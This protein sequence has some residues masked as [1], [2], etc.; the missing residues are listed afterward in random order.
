LDEIHHGEAQ[1][2]PLEVAK[3]HEGFYTH[4]PK[5]EEA[6]VEEVPVKRS[7]AGYPEPTY[8]EGQLESTS[9]H[10]DLDGHPLEH[11]VSVY[12]PGKYLHGFFSFLDFLN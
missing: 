8:Y 12:A 6:K 1:Q 4:L 10:S 2:H 5:H 3:Y 9:R 7:V 11:H